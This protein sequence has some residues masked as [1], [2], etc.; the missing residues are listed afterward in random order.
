MCRT[1]SGL[2]DNWRDYKADPRVLTESLRPVRPVAKQRKLVLTTGE[3][4]TF[5]VY[6]LNDTGA[7][8]NGTLTLSLIEPDGAER[9]L[10]TF[11]APQYERDRMS[12]LLEEDVQTPLLATAGTWK[13]RL[14][15][16]SDSRPRTRGTCW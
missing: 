1:D 8:V 7:A 9:K 5:D 12:Y 15:L 2:V 6:L 14:Y 13:W 4:A 16:S 10:K 11:E 3:K